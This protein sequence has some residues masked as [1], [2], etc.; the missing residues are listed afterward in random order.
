MSNIDHRLFG[1]DELWVAKDPDFAAIGEASFAGLKYID[2][3][4]KTGEQ[5]Y[6]GYVGKALVTFIV[7]CVIVRILHRPPS[8]YPTHVR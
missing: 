4:D 6:S 8:Q 3:G 1:D 7:R 2:P 5:V